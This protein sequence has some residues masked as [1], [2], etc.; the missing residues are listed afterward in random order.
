MNLEQYRSFQQTFLALAEEGKSLAD[1]HGFSTLV[2]LFESL[3]KRV[4]EERFFVSVLGEIK[5]G[6]STLIDA[7][8]QADIMP[9]TAAV[10]TAALCLV[11]HADPARACLRYRDGR[12]QEIPAHELKNWVTRRNPQVHTIDLVDV[13]FPLPLLQHGVV[14]VDT[15]GVNDTDE[16]RRRLTEEFIPRSDGVLFVLNIGQPLSSS[17]MVFLTG[18]VLRHN[19]RKVWFVINGVDRVSDE[20]ERREAI[21]YCEKHLREVLPDARVFPVSAKTALN[22]VLANP[23]DTAAHQASGI[24]DLT[25]FLEKELVAGRW[26]SLFDVPL[27]QLSH[28]LGDVLKSL[29]WITTSFD[30]ADRDRAQSLQALEQRVTELQHERERLLKRFRAAVESQM[31]EVVNAVPY[32][33]T[34]FLGD[35]VALILGMDIPEDDKV[36]RLSALG[37]EA[38]QSHGQLLLERLHERVTPVARD[39]QKQMA[40]LISTLDARAGLTVPQTVRQIEPLELPMPAWFGIE[41]RQLLSGFGRAASLVFALQGNFLLAAASLAFGL[42]T[43]LSKADTLKIV[44]LLRDKL[45]ET[46]TKTCESFLQQKDKISEAYAG[47]LNDHFHSVFAFV[48]DFCRREKELMSCSADSVAREKSLIAARHEQ[49]KE[50]LRRVN[51]LESGVRA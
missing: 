25:T 19:I 13:G 39:L 40:E 7:L 36:Q 3:Q 26:E 6:K 4:R 30:Q 1:A 21:A 20:N 34:E 31:F 16:V 45:K 2:S 23:R 43:K 51:E 24:P 42:A 10:C 41:G 35:S 12:R 29:E 17:E 37:K 48:D 32:P 47:S 15:P 18:S 9:R 50:L 5:R 33:P 38:V 8:L 28:L 11:S 44:P 22:A 46:G 49:L 27:A 14:I